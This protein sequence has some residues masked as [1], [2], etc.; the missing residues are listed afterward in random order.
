[1]TKVYYY[2]KLKQPV[3]DKFTRRFLKGLK[4]CCNDKLQLLQKE[5]RFRLHDAHFN[6]FV[7][8]DAWP[9]SVRC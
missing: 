8:R 3:Q 5:L 6:K 4:N 2:G 1:M 9:F 7:G